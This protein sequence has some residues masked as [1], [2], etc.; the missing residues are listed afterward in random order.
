MGIV[1]IDYLWVVIL[2]R[3]RMIG[4][5]A[6][7]F[8]PSPWTLKNVC[9][10]RLKFWNLIPLILCTRSWNLILKNLLILWKQWNY[11]RRAKT[12]LKVPSNLPLSPRKDSYLHH[13]SLR[14]LLTKVLL[15]KPTLISN[16]ALLLKNF[17]L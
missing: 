11:S 15:L 4:R 17:V 7:D 14:R 12:F 16:V 3:V 9:F 13:C 2:I 5:G 10:S 1:W 6:R 8:L